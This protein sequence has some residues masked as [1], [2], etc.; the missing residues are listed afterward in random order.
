[1]TNEEPLDDLDEQPAA[2]D[3]GGQGFD[4]STLS[5]LQ[6]K[7]PQLGSAG[8]RQNFL[9]RRRNVCSFARMHS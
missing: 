9:R 6:E 4:D 5:E 2:A 7:R 8:R 1:M 3:E